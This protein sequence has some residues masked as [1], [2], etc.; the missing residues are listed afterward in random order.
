LPVVEILRVDRQ[1]DKHCLEN[2]S[3]FTNCIWNVPEV[4]SINVKSIV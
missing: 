3:S 1:M 4:E 2:R